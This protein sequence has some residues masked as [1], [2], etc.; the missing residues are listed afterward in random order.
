MFARYL[1]ALQL[2]LGVASFAAPITTIYAT[3]YG[4]VGTAIVA[5]D[6]SQVSWTRPQL[7]PLEGAIAVGADGIRTMRRENNSDTSLYPFNPN[8]P[9]TEVDVINGLVAA[10]D[11]GARG[12]G[13]NYLVDTTGGG[14][15]MCETDWSNCSLLFSNGFTYS[16]IAYD[17]SDGTIWLSRHNP[18]NI[19]EHRTLAGGLLSSFTTNNFTMTGLALDS[20]SST[21]YFGDYDDPSALFGYTKQ[22]QFVER[23]HYAEL[24]VTVFM[25]LD[26][27]NEVPE[28]GTGLLALCGAVMVSLGHFLHRRA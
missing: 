23:V 3:A 16:G 1:I 11:D 28:P 10:A 21:L 13:V 2:S 17:W 24:N 26:T 20:A 12:D 18:F 22:G 5:I 15:H 25:G 14:V 27:Q 9:A 19:I 6:G 7:K 4:N 8:D